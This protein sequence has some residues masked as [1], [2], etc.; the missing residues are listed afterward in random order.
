M[1]SKKCEQLLVGQTFD[2]SFEGGM[3]PHGEEQ[4]HQ[5]VTLLT[6][7]P[8][9]NGVN[10]TLIILPLIRRGLGEEQPHKGQDRTTSIHLGKSLQHGPP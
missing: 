10:H 2:G 8:F 4:W 6:T 3:L 9:M 1:S 7:L 5:S